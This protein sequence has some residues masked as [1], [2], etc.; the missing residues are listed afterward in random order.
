MFGE[1][2]MASLNRHPD[3][4]IYSSRYASAAAGA[5]QFMPFTWSFVGSKLGFSKF[6]PDEQDQGALFYLVEYRKAMSLT[7]KG[8]VMSPQLSARLAPELASFPTLRGKSDNELASL[9][10]AR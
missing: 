1:G 2:L 5:Y 6:G 9:R 4:V 10:Q 3:R 7:D 8:G